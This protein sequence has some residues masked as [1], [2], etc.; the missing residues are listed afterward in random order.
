MSFGFAFI[1]FIDSAH[2]F[3]IHFWHGSTELYSFW[4]QSDKD[5]AIFEKLRNILNT[6]KPDILK[7]VIAREN[8]RPHF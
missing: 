4:L 8:L 2:F 1:S 6:L 3:R 7:T 5:L